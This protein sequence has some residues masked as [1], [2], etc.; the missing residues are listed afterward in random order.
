MYTLDGGARLSP[1]LPN[2]VTRRQDLPA[3]YVLNGAAYV[4]DAQWLT[5]T[6]SFLT[7]ETVAYEMP[8]ERSLD[9]DTE[10]DLAGVE[11]YLR[12]HA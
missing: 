9:I 8:V 5:R 3:V 6:G 7:A 4:A 11:S 1:V 12:A 2:R 10:A